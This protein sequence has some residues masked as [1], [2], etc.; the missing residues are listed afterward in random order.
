MRGG[1]LQACIYPLPYPHKDQGCYSE[2]SQQHL[3]RTESHKA[4][5]NPSSREPQPWTGAAWS[6]QKDEAKAQKDQGGKKPSYYSLFFF[7]S[8]LL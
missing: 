1:F 3:Q 4:P 7:T 8:A 5:E 6:R 2:A